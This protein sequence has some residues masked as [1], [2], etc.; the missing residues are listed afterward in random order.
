MIYTMVHSYSEF[1]GHVSYDV[2][3]QGE[4]VTMAM[5]QIARSTECISG[6][7]E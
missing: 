1:K 7:S 6:K 2:M 4:N 5:G 3:P